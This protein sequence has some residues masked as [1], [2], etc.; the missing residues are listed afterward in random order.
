MSVSAI[1]GGA[2]DRYAVVGDPISHSKSP[3]IHRLFAEQ[4]GQNLVYEAIRIDSE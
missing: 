1:S 3:L 2:P 4:T